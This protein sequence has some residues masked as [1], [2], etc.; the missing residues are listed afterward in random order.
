M[1]EVHNLVTGYGKAVIVQGVSLEVKPGELVTIIGPNGA[2]KS[3]LIKAIARL[4]PTFS[5]EVRYN[6]VNIT[7]L[8]PDKLIEIGINYVPQL[9]N[10]FPNMT[11]MENLE[12]GALKNENAFER[13]LARVFE[14]FP[15]LEERQEQKAKKLSGGERQML[16]LARA[17]M[18]DPQLLLLDEPTAALAP[19][20]VTEILKIIKTLKEKEQLSIL[21]VEQNARKSLEICDRAYILVMGKVARTGTGKELLSDPELGKAFLGA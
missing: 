18:S 4:I 7:N 6:G 9:E 11:V 2:G 13:N 15:I 10:V 19:N 8:P 14:I 16:A 20:L 1:L 3:T 5:G 21:L 12:M 17:L